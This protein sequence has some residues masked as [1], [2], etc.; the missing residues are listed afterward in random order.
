MGV[1]VAVEA[2]VLVLLTLLVTGLLRSHA[3]ILRQ[4][5]ALGAGLD[6]EVGIE[7]PV[8]LRPRG[9]VARA[10][11]FGPAHDIAGAG[12]RDDA[13][14]VPVV[15]V[16]HR[17][18]LAFLSSGC[19]TCRAFWEALADERA[20]GLPD[21]VRVL[22]VTMDAAEESTPALRELAPP[23]LPV[24]MSSDAWRTYD[25][26]GS[27]YFILVDGASGRVQG[28]GT[29]VTWDQVRNLILQAGDDMVDMARE[30]QVDHEL[31]AAGVAPGDPSLYRR[32]DEVEGATQP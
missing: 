16:R 1:L 21:D 27:P 6:P 22:A 20:L 8:A 12:L 10:N 7:S 11:E 17:T 4:L 13:L 19:L 14:I 3:D 18:L 28:E 29:G 31:L 30:A 25:V 9:D 5:H 24:V 23:D 26:P 2:V 15:G 32:I